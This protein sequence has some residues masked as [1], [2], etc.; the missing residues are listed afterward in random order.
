MPGAV[1][2]K[3]HICP[4]MPAP[5]L[6]TRESSDWRMQ[7]KQCR[8]MC[9]WRGLFL[10]HGAKDAR[11][12]PVAIACSLIGP[13]KTKRSDAHKALAIKRY[14][15]NTTWMVSSR[16]IFC[17]GVHMSHLQACLRRWQRSPTAHADTPP[18]LRSARTLTRGCCAVN[19]PISVKLNDFRNQQILEVKPPRLFQSVRLVREP[20]M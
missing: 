9:G 10:P 3:G 16:S 17:V 19:K 12:R 2:Q 11:V 5:I 1:S 8:H 18:A 6:F 7:H 4:K 15:S 13:G 14:M 20:A